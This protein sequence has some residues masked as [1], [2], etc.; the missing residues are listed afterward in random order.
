MYC[1]NKFRSPASKAAEFTVGPVLEDPALGALFTL[2]A[3][4][5]IPDDKADIVQEA[6]WEITDDEGLTPETRS[7]LGALPVSD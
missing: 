3:K 6:V 2:L 1:A 7:A 5:Q 4:K